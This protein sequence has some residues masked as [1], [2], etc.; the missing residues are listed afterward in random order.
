MPTNLYID[1]SDALASGTIRFR[2]IPVCRYSLTTEHEKHIYSKREFIRIYRDMAMIR[3]FETMLSDLKEKG[4]YFGTKYKLTEPLHLAIGEEA[5]AVG[6][7]YCMEPKD[8]LFGTHRNHATTIAKGL[9]AIEKLTENELVMVMRSYFGGDILAPIAE[10]ADP[11]SPVKDIACD[12]FLYGLLSEIFGKKTGF[13]RGLAGSSDLS[14]LPFG[15]YPCNSIPAGSVGFAVGAALYKKNKGEKGFVT[16]C[17]GDGALGEGAVWEALNLASMDQ[18]REIWN[19]DGSLP[20]LFTIINNHYAMD[21]QPVG[22]TMGFKKAARIGAGI[23]PEQMHAERV[24]G[25]DPM[26][27][28]DAIARKK[29]LLEREEGPLL[30]ELVTYR[31]CP[32]SAGELLDER[33]KEELAAWKAHDPIKCYRDKL[34]TGGIARENELNEIDLGIRRRLTNICRLAADSARSPMLSSAEAEALVFA[35]P[36]TA[37][38]TAPLYPEVTLSRAQ[39]SRTMKIDTKSRFGYDENGDPI[40]KNKRYNLK[41]AI[42]EPILARFYQDSS[43]SVYGACVRGGRNAVLEDLSEAIPFHRFFNTPLSEAAII[44][45]AIGYAMCGGSAVVEIPYAA[46]LAHAGDEL[47]NQLAKCRALSGGVI[48]LPLIIRVPIEK[49]RGPKLSSD[50]S[51][52]VS[53]IPGLKVLYPVTPYDM[54]GLLASALTDNNPV[55]VFEN[56]RLYDIGECFR[57]DGVPHEDYTLPLGLADIK[58]GGKDITILTIGASLYHAMEASSRLEGYGV[59]AEIIDARSLVPFDY[60]TVLRSVSK[61]GKLLIVGE[62]PERGSLMRDIASNITELSFDLL[63]APPVVVGARNLPVFAPEDRAFPVAE[64]ILDAIHQKILPL[65]DYTSVTKFSSTEKL[66]RAKEGI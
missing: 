6:E 1:P 2:D 10:S 37:H 27:V 35:T 23:A 9:S 11:S 15:I 22:E 17:L 13:N 33:I 58:K 25:T 41:D 59:D 20:L 26:A 64:T 44:S 49:N 46:L 48:K 65:K 55:I 57:E 62:S 7:A 24:N 51:S 40:A 32:H 28:I 53:S 18:I 45:S 8:I 50:L 38:P 42:F 36:Q 29:E 14:F 63:D 12:F 54:K 52:L 56:E 31:E 21:C 47:M 16:A 4:E 5:V 19:K 39:C 61:T 43:F 66:R 30:L 3:E 60:E 34:L